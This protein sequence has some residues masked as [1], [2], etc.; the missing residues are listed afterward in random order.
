MR[1]QIINSKHFCKFILLQ[2]LLCTGV[3]NS[4]AQQYYTPSN[5]PFEITTG[6]NFFYIPN[7]ENPIPASPFLGL[8]FRAPITDIFHLNSG[9]EY[10]WINIDEGKNESPNFYKRNNYLKLKIIPQ[11]E[12]SDFFKLSAGL[13]VSVMMN[14]K[15]II[16]DGTLPWGYS[17]ESATPNFNTTVDYFTGLDLALFRRVGFSANA[18]LSL[19]DL[20]NFISTYQFCVRYAINGTSYR[21]NDIAK[22]KNK[23]VKKSTDS[24]TDLK[25]N[26]AGA[27]YFSFTTG[28]SFPMG[29]FA[30]T[31][32]MI[33]PNG[34]AI[35]GFYLS[36]SHDYQYKFVGWKTGV[37]FGLNPLNKDYQNQI[38]GDLAGGTESIKIGR[39][40]NFK[41]LTG[42]QLTLQAKKVIMQTSYMV[43]LLRLSYPDITVKS[44]DLAYEH[45]IQHVGHS[46]MMQQFDVSLFYCINKSLQLGLIAKYQYSDSKVKYI[47]TAKTY[48]LG[49]TYYGDNYNGIPWRINNSLPYTGVH[50]NG[51]IGQQRIERTIFQKYSALNIGVTLRVKI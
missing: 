24:Q 13:Q 23:P 21:K 7:I 47:E 42:P 49:N 28:P 18:S 31:D 41:F 25:D 22:K 38:E 48:Q 6:V 3:Q 10:T 46:N 43:G 12:L 33:G 17:K 4:Y 5:Y 29:E 30:N 16:I 34:N 26:S 44:E 32:N 40:T 20:D 35:P 51:W 27:N 11:F 9:V 36:V 37:E 15:Q 50:Y 1:K 19:T 45:K 8:S 2:I 14:A 39:W